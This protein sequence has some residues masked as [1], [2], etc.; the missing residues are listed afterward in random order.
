V[1]G[2]PPNIS[3]RRQNGEIAAS[4]VV[5]VVKGSNVAK[6]LVK[7][8]IEAAGMWYQVE[9]YMNTDPDSRCELCCGWGHIKNKFGS[10]PSCGFYSGH[11]RTSDPKCNVVGCTVMQE[12]LCSHTLEKCSNCK[13]NHIVFTN[14]YAKK[15]EAAKAAWQ[16]SG[17]WPERRA[18]ANAATG[19]SSGTNRVML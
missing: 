7:K 18:Q 5:F 10:K 2:E 19:V 14:R 17:I 8:G 3:E 16:N 1:A 4:S 15:T 9:T 6:G 11:H 12:S 13:G